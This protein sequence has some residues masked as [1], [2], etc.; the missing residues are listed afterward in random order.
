MG[1][2]RIRRAGIF[3]LRSSALCAAS[4]MAQWTAWASIRV[5]SSLP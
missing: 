4:S 2:Q 5:K 1:E 3:S